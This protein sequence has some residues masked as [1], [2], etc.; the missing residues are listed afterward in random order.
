MLFP[1]LHHPLPC[2][3]KTLLILLSNQTTTAIYMNPFYILFHVLPPTK[4]TQ[5][6]L[7]T[8]YTGI[9]SFLPPVLNARR[10]W[11]IEENIKPPACKVSQ[12][13]TVRCI[14]TNPRKTE[15]KQPK[16][17]QFGDKLARELRQ[18]AV[19]CRNLNHLQNHFN[20]LKPQLVEYEK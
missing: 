8:D 11:V 2:L 9:G 6:A 3:W 16:S 10:T 13:T 5:D 19:D 1:I 20:D 14:S 12:S 4:L 7:P 18:N 15:G 17:K